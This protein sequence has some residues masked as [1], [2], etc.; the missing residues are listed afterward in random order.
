[1]LV[2]YAFR[3]VQT[4][5]ILVQKV[6]NALHSNFSIFKAKHCISCWSQQ[7]RCS[8]NKAL[9]TYQIPVPIPNRRHLVDLKY[10]YLLQIQKKK[11]KLLD[12]KGGSPGLV[13][14]E[15]DSCPEG[16]GLECQHRALDGHFSHLFVLN[17]VMLFFKRQNKRKRGRDGTF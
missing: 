15:R 6:T 4:T 14:M 12:E 10:I 5:A 9:K 2:Y 8:L 11:Y 3:L 17:I 16:C 1:M 7:N 13:V